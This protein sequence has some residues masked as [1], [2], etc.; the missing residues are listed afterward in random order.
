MRNVKVHSSGLM[1]LFYADMILCI[2]FNKNR[3]EKSSCRFS[4]LKIRYHVNLE[5]SQKDIKKRS[6]ISLLP[7]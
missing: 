1:E 5:E 3:R 7:R 6:N 2:F 4:L